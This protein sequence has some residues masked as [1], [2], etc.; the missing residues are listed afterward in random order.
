MT[1]SRRTILIIGMADSI[2]LARWVAQFR[3][4]PIDFTI[5]PS[6]PHRRIHPLLRDLMTSSSQPMSVAIRPQIMRWTA[7]VFC[8]IDV[9]FHNFFRARMLRHLLSKCAFDYIHV[10]ELQHAGY[11]LLDTKITN[12]DSKIILTNWGSDVYWYQRFPK[13]RLRIEELLKLADA[14]SAEC[15]RDIDLVRSLGYR[16]IVLPLIPNSGGIDPERIPKV[17]DLTSRRRNIMVKGYTGFVGQALIAL[18]ACELIASELQDYQIVVYSASIRT[19][20]RLLRLKHSLGL[21]VKRL[22]KRTPHDEMLRHFSE[23]RVYIGIS[24]SDGISTSLLESMATGCYPIQTDTSCAREWISDV[25]GSLVS[26]HDVYQISRE[27]IT[28]LTDDR[29]VD[30]ASQINRATIATRATSKSVIDKAQSFY[31][32]SVET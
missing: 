3:S 15:Q 4:Y 28:A 26:V 5:F 20:I 12:V 2:H 29:K 19:R 32:L 22:R 16:G 1:T 27:L 10:M 9:L 6:S 7:L 23:A 13:H 30:I 31:E 8:A 11:I 14:Y 24:L 18:A 25:S 17:L 21:R